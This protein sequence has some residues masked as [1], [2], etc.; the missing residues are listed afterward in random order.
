MDVIGNLK[1]AL[2]NKLFFSGDMHKGVQITETMLLTGKSLINKCSYRSKE[3]LL[4]ALLGNY[5]TNRPT[6]QQTMDGH[7]GFNILTY[8]I[9]LES[10]DFVFC[11]HRSACFS[12]KTRRRFSFK[13][14]T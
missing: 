10:V 8:T 3:V 14:L 12:K 7:E 2:F 13:H 9:I 11:E 5:M 1:S 6:D 4:S